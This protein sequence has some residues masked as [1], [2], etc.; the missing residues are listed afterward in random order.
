MGWEHE[1]CRK[2]GSLL[3]FSTLRDESHMMSKK[4]LSLCLTSSGDI[5]LF[6]FENRGLIGFS[7]T[8]GTVVIEHGYE[9]QL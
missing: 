1:I 6:F 9:Y 3:E 4:L 2:R 7:D 8:V 5:F